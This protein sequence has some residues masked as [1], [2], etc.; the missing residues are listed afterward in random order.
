MQVRYINSITCRLLGGEK[1]F[2]NKSNNYLQVDYNAYV[3]MKKVY[4]KNNAVL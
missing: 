4:L 2:R 3:Q 1:H